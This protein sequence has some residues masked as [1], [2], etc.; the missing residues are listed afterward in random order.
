M[1]R[2]GCACD[3]QL[4]QLYVQ[5]STDCELSFSCMLRVLLWSRWYGSQFS[6]TTQT[7]DPVVC[8]FVPGFAETVPDPSDW[9][10]MARL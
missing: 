8:C 4:R 3:E 6:I 7:Q 5:Y 10:A 9:N 1:Y 2:S